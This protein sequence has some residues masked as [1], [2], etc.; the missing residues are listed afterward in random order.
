[1][2]IIGYSEMLLSNSAT[3][4]DDAVAIDYLRIINTA[5]RDGA[6]WYSESGV[7]PNTVVR[8]DPQAGSMQLWKIPSG[9]GTVRNMV[10]APDGSLWLAC[11]GVNKLA[12]VMMKEVAGTK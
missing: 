7:S 3:R 9:G 10:A 2:S 5:G 1:M 11:S 12:H 6:L 4:S 8:F